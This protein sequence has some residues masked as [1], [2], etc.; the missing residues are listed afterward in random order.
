MTDK[1]GIRDVELIP[2][3]YI[4]TLKTRQPLMIRSFSELLKEA[5]TDFS[6]TI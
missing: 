1:Q 3:V 2:E 4:F 5:M 6:R